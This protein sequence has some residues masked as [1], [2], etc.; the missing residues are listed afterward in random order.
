MWTIGDREGQRK[1]RLI[2]N[3]AVRK[4]SL[5]TEEPASFGQ[6]RKRRSFEARRKE[7]LRD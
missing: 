2:E 4:T 3:R 6:R 7:Q 5:P 1:S